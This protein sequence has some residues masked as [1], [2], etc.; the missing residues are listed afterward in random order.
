MEVRVVRW[1]QDLCHGRVLELLPPVRVLGCELLPRFSQCWSLDS[2]QLPYSG[3]AFACV[4]STLRW[5]AVAS[6]DLPTVF[7]LPSSRSP[8]LLGG[9]PTG[10]V[11]EFGR[12]EGL[13]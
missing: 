9:I 2:S 1:G 6:V 5:T 10:E 13:R 7:S 11:V 8:T 12:S 4:R 3:P